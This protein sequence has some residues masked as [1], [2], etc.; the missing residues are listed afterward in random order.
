MWMSILVWWDSVWWG[1]TT[2]LDS[3]DDTDSRGRWFKHTQH[4]DKNSVDTKHE[5]IALWHELTAD[6]Y[7][8]NFS[9]SDNF[10]LAR[11]YGA[12]LLHWQHI[13]EK[14]YREGGSKLRYHF[15]LVSS[16]V[17]EIVVVKVQSCPK[18]NIFFRGGAGCGS[19][20][21]SATLSWWWGLCTDDPDDYLI[22]RRGANQ[23]QT[24]W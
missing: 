19:P 16:S 4:W 12:C 6:T 24:T 1:R 20:P 23:A 21:W 8:Q 18:S 10:L 11:K 13:H 15:L 2:T 14:Q 22:W 3:D 7:P 17:L 9:T 5:P